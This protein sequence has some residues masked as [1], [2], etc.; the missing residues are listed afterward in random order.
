MSIQERY[1]VAEEEAQEREKQ[2]RRERENKRRQDQIQNAVG[3]TMASIYREAE[4]RV[5]RM[6][7]EEKQA[8]LA[9]YG[10]A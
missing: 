7:P 1:L 10:Y 6:T 3:E 9:K 4:D 2:R 8:L 5:S